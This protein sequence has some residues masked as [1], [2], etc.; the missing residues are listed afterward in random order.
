MLT[1][2]HV[3][4][5]SGCNDVVG[6]SVEQNGG[7]W[8]EVVIDEGDMDVVACLPNS[9]FTVDDTI[10][11]EDGEKI[12]IWGHVT[13][14]GL[15]DMISDQNLVKKTGT[16]TGT[17]YGVPLEIY[18][19]EDGCSGSGSWEGLKTELDSAGG[20]SGGPVYDVR[21]GDA[22]MVDLHQAGS[23]SNGSEC[24]TDVTK[25]SYG[26]T[27]YQINERLGGSFVYGTRL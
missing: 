25:Y 27:A 8:G 9:N 4:D 5:E 14:Y 16:T 11:E 6:N 21:D 20:D 3:L 19:E 18:T 13:K 24:D 22:Y 23:G 10:L 15:Y 26:V 2:A 12:P 1:A 7:I 17:E